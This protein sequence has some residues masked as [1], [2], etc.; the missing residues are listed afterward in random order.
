LIFTRILAATDGTEVALRGVELA[1]QM[2]ARDG[3]EFLLLTAVP[4]PQHVAL[5]ANVGRR[6]IYSYV[7]RMAQEFLAPAVA[8]LRRTGVGAAVK[9]V[10]GPPAEALLAEIESSGADLVVMG[11]RSRVE[12]KDLILGD[13]SYR[14]ARHLRVPILLVP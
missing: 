4:M 13:V 6:T 1:A 14:V 11:R 7:E 10:I 9:V 8:I 2:A 3:A 5:A 12:P